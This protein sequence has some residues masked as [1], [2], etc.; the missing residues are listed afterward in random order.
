MS[1]SRIFKQLHIKKLPDR[2]IRRQ[3]VDKQLFKKKKKRNGLMKLE[4]ESIGDDEGSN[5]EE[6]EQ[7]VVR[8]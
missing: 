2:I 1:R 8:R 3:I 5:Q 6:A 4:D 7:V